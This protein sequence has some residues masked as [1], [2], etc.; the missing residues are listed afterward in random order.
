MDNWQTHKYKIIRA[1]EQTDEE[2]KNIQGMSEKNTA[3]EVD[4]IEQL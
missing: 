3:G 2:K 4:K 1:L